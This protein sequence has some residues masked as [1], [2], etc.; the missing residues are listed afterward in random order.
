[1][2]HA[3][4]HV[5]ADAF[6][7]SCELVRHPE[8]RGKPIC[9]MSS[10]D[11]CIVAKTYDA[12]AAGIKTGMPVWE[13]KRL[14]PEAAYFSADFRYYG[15]ISD[16][17]FSILGRYSPDVE[18]T[19]IDEGFV[20]LDGLSRLWKKNAREI[21]QA[22]AASIRTEIGITVSIGASVTRTLAK[23]ASEF[24]KPEG[25]TVV[26]AARIKDF[27]AQVPASAIP[28][29]GGNRAALL[30]KHGIHSALEFAEYPY[31]GNLL[32]KC[33]LD[34]WHELN[35]SRVFL[36]TAPVLPKS[37]SRTASLGIL[38]RDKQVLRD[39]LSLHAMRMSRELMEKRLGTRELAV[40]LTRE[41]F[42]AATMTI[43]LPYPTADYFLLVGVAQRALDAL[44]DP[45][46]LWRGCGL[47]AR[48]IG[49][50]I[51]MD[52]FADGR[53]EEKHLKLLRT[54]HAINRKYGGGALHAGGLCREREVKFDY[55]MLECT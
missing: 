8:L 31:C 13:A 10:Q 7:A 40:F 48:K 19:S 43:E 27:L 33:G 32:G 29:I 50:D 55:P 3:V 12:K 11:A 24:R 54:M 21:A 35:G 15:Q 1:M 18:S 45:G 47:I 5:D 4:L 38:T 52:L 26:S 37:V 53:R 34:L 14:M 30:G 23:M 2:P 25:V 42:A 28:G 36:K 16:K 20:E 22:M 6:Y 17:F 49:E 41:S 9:V 46:Q 44:F 39:N 51:Q